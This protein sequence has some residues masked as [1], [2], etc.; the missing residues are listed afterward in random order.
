[1]L[2]AAIGL[3]P[4]VLPAINDPAN[5]LTI[6][7][8]AAD[9]YALRVALFWWIPGMILAGGYTVFSYRSFTGKVRLEPGGY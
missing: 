8:A 9:A 2:S 6:Y 4:N 3:F 5:S 7:N 1:M